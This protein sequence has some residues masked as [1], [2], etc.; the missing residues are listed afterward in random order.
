MTDL[1]LLDDGIA[2]EFAPFSLT[3]PVSELRTGAL[4]QRERWERASGARAIG[5]IGA[6][7]LEDFDE[8]GA[9]KTA[10]G[11]IKKGTIVV[12]SRCV[13]ALPKRALPAADVWR[14]AGQVAAVKL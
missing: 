6:P 11:T 5:F 2:R 4:L 9:A 12:N 8:P 3:R 10:S 7:H 13:V 14:C 1:V